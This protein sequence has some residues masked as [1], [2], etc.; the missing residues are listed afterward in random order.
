[1]QKQ[2]NAMQ[3]KCR[4]VAAPI[5]TGTTAQHHPITLETTRLLREV[6]DKADSQAQGGFRVAS[7]AIHNELPNP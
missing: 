4:P 3:N 7:N 2:H 6:S 5:P 1:M